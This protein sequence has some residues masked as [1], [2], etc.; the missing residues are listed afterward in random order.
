VLA[1]ALERKDQADS[2][3]LTRV[4]PGIGALLDVSE[5]FVMDMEQTDDA[6]IYPQSALLCC[7]SEQSQQ[8]G[9]LCFRQ[10]PCS[11]VPF[12]CLC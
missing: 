9:Q 1:P 7:E 6:L 11:P 5:P 3:D 12:T 4:Q 10:L 2:D 8:R